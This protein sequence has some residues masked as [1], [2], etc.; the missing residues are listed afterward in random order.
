MSVQKRSCVRA[1]QTEYRPTA[2]LHPPV[3]SVPAPPDLRHIDAQ[4]LKL[5]PVKSHKAQRSRLIFK[6][7]TFPAKRA[8]LNHMINNNVTKRACACDD[9]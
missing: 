2:H 6:C 9:G 8:P 5:K 4:V 3:D 1:E 7:S